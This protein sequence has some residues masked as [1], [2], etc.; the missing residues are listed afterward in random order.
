[1]STMTSRCWSKIPNQSLMTQILSLRST[2]ENISSF[3][4][5]N[6]IKLKDFGCVAGGASEERERE[7]VWQEK[8]GEHNHQIGALYVKLGD[9][10]PSLLSLLN[11]FFLKS[12]SSPFQTEKRLNVKEKKRTHADIIPDSEK[13]FACARKFSELSHT[14]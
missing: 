14:C 11:Q 10:K 6:H 8:R 4:F 1:M 7:K 5:C 13:P 3:H 12:K 9:H 2:N